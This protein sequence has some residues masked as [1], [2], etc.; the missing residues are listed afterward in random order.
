MKKLIL[1]LLML[2]C[3]TACAAEPTVPSPEP[4]P[5][6]A[7]SPEP[8]ASPTPS[9]S[10]SPSPTP[11]PTPTATPTPTPTPTPVPEPENLLGPYF[12]SYTIEEK[13]EILRERFPDKM[14]WNHSGIDISGLSQ[15]EA[16]LIY[17]DIPCE[18]SNYGYDNCHF[19]NST[20]MYWF[21]Y[22]YNMECLGF[23]SF[24]SDFLFGVESEIREY[25]SFDDVRVGDHIR[26]DLWDHSFIVTEVGVNEEGEDY[27]KVVECNRNFE[28]CLIEWDRVLTRSDIY[29]YGDHVTYLTRY[30]EVEEVSEIEQTEDVEIE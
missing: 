8:A 9:P 1:V 12:D 15:E 10:P 25:W 13:I 11:T 26:L 4:S 14:Y 2:L 16:A 28:D 27:I 17:T 18:H 29:S 20:T 5:S 21:G 24:V 3:L 30:P 22:S 7:V 19:Y 23:A 6:P